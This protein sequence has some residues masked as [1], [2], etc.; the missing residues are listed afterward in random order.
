MSN[1]THDSW[2]IYGAYGFTGRLIVE[3]ALRRGHRPVLAGRDAEQLRSMAKPL[4]LEI[5]PLSLDDAPSL[6]LAARSSSLIVNAAGPFSET[7]PKIIDACLKTSTPYVD[8]SGEFHHLRAVEALDE[9]AREAGIPL[10]TG[11]GFGVT[12][13][14]CLARHVVDRLPDATSLLISVAANNAQSTP[15]VR[16]TILDVIAKGGYAVEGGSWVKRPLAHQLWTVRDGSTDTPFA[17][18]PM[19]ELAAARTSTSV[20][21]IVVGRPMPAKT[22]KRL[23]MVSPLLQGAL[24]IAPLRR[25]LGRDSGKPQIPTP[26]P[27][28]GW[29][30]QLWAEARNARGDRAVAR[31]ETGEGY[32]FT[33]RAALANIEALFT[34]K[35]A[36]AFTPARAFG[37]EH[38]LTIPGVR[39]IDLDPESFSPLE[40]VHA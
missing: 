37:A 38:V 16:R 7:G 21:N 1:V 11:G 30:S 19:G 20:A 12:F 4:E 24:S 27:K 22:A 35:L 32:A 15:A 23:R 29:R 26:E 8:I 3:E 17:A 13:G 28:Q 14:D 39:L 40:R 2:M 36:G 5:M 31:L 34:R 33:A 10:L 25:A 6:G 18:A 9:Q